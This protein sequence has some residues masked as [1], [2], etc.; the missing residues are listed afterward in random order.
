ML[1]DTMDNEE[2]AARIAEGELKMLGLDP[3]KVKIAIVTHAHADDYGGVSYFAQK[4]GSQI[5]ASGADSKL[6]EKVENAD[7]P[8]W[9]RPP[10]RGVA[11]T[12]D[13]LVAPGY[14]MGAILAVV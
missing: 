3:A 13:V 14:T 4:Y 8:L 6:M 2:D 11:I 12:I 10:K 7:N 1:I 9:S 5:V